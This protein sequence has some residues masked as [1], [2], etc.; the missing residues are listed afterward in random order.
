MIL[1]KSSCA[2]VQHSSTGILNGNTAFSVRYELKYCVQFDLIL[3]FKAVHSSAYHPGGS[4]STPQCDICGGRIGTGSDSSSPCTLI[5]PSHY[6]STDSPYPSSSTCYS[7]RR[8]N[9][10]S[11]VTF[12]IAMLQLWPFFLPDVYMDWPLL[13][14]YKNCENAYG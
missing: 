8:T 3:F 5:L 14:N 2:T 12:Q 4:D 13:T 11:L 1:I 9:G 10:R 7:T 6:H